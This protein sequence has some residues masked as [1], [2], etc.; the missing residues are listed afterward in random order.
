MDCGENGIHRST[1]KVVDILLLNQN[2]VSLV[3]FRQ[4]KRILQNMKNGLNRIW[5]AFGA[6][7]RGQLER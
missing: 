5:S 2:I 1:S 7:M 4:R 3:N 6:R